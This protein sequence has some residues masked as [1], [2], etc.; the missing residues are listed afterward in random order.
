MSFQ[1]FRKIVMTFILIL[2]LT[3][4]FFLPVRALV[5]SQGDSAIYTFLVAEKRFSLKWIHSVEKEVWVENF[6]IEGQH[7]FLESTHFKTFGA[8]TP[9]TSEQPIKLKN[10]WLHLDVNRNIG[11]SL[12]V[13]ATM[14]NNYQLI[15]KGEKYPLV[16]S[17]ISYRI[18]EKTTTMIKVVF[19]AVKRLFY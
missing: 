18:E 6:R 1:P 8:G 16:E 12:I 5:I 7:I 9:S 15:I 10:G 19:S 11:A 3:G 4:I 13:R 14:N 17:N 2:I